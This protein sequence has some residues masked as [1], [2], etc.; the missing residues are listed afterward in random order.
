MAHL[1]C[2]AQGGAHQRPHRRSTPLLCEG[3]GEGG[4]EITHY[5]PYERPTNQD[6]PEE[7]EVGEFYDKLVGSH[8]LF[9]C[10]ADTHYRKLDNNYIKLMSSLFIEF[11]RNQ[12]CVGTRLCR[13]WLRQVTI[14][15]NFGSPTSS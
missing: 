14:L 15:I 4:G 8:S 7:P 5:T 13:I 1:W 2:L 10:N 3:G 11:T 9:Y 6:Q 12:N